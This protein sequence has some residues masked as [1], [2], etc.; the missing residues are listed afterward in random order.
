MTDPTYRLRMVDAGKCYTKYNDAPML[1]G[2]L[3]L[4]QRTRREKLWA[5]RHVDVE[6]G[7]GETIGLIGRNGSGKSTTL[8]MLAGVTAP[9]E[10]RVSVRG[11]VAPLISVGVGFHMELTGRENVYVNGT[12]LGMPRRM[13]D[14]RL[15]A[16]IDFAEIEDFMD[17]PVKFYSSGM[18]VRLGFAVA[19]QADPDILLVDEV[20][21]VGDLGFQV[22]CYNRMN[23]IKAQ[24]TTIVVVSHNLHAVKTMA[25]RS[26]VLHKGQVRYDGDTA[27]AISVFHGLMSD[28]TEEAVGDAARRP[29]RI[30]RADLVD[31]DGDITRHVPTGGTIVLEVKVA[32]DEDVADPAVGVTV[33][34]ETGTHVFNDSTFANPIGP[35]PAGSVL[36]IRSSMRVPLTAGTFT[37][38]AAVVSLPDPDDPLRDL[39]TLCESDRIPFFVSNHGTAQGVADLGARFSWELGRSTSN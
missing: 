15:D 11:R 6:V 22:K 17:T 14:A 1:V 26:L 34:S 36:R 20:L 16:I 10:G 13:I 9:T 30:L 18:V 4:R 28:P 37:A 12:I 29:V 3:S 7:P 21:A 27:T 5:V 23:E 31:E 8:Q 35:C 2:S 38:R 33:E 39:R 32:F 19:V 25:D 24:G